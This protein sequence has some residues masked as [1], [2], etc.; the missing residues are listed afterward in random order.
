MSQ[1][2]KPVDHACGDPFLQWPRETEALVH[3]DPGDDAG[4]IFITLDGGSE[5]IHQPLLRLRG[6]LV[7]IGHLGPDEEA[8][9]IRPVE[10]A[11]VFNFLM[12][13][14]SVEAQGLRELDVVTEIAVGGGGVPTARKVSLVQHQSLNVGLAIQQET[15]VACPDGAH[16][17]ISINLVEV[18]ATIVDEPDGE[19]VERRMLR[20]P[21][22]D[23]RKRQSTASTPTAK[24]AD[25]ASLPCDVELDVGIGL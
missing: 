23:L 3:R 6:V 9:T 24:R 12:L 13:A 25:G 8:K 5:L 14:R 7:K 15:P 22:V 2:V 20:T 17:E 16:A 11:G 1:V 4:V 10:P 18:A 19:L 21:G